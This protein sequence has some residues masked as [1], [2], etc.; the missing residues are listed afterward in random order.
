MSQRQIG[1]GWPTGVVTTTDGTTSTPVCL[2]A[3]LPN[4]STF[5]IEAYLQGR[6][7]AGN[8]ASTQ[9][10]HRGKVVSGTA[11]LVGSLTGIVSFA[12]GSDTILATS[13]ALIDISAGAARLNVTGV[14]ATT[15]EWFGELY[16]RVN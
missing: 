11:A 8:I 4:G 7:A 13:T 15:I 3:A 1:F 14:A 9:L 10:S 6:D 5:T 12:T 2:S 16:I